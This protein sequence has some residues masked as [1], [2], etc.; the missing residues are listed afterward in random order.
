MQVAVHIAVGDEHEDPCRCRG[1]P[2]EPG[3]AHP[4][5][6]VRFERD[7]L[8]VLQHLG[9]PLGLEIDPT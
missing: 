1:P 7:Q 8:R 2:D 9:D 4:G 5:L 6:R 3:G